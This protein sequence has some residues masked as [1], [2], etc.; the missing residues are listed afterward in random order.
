MMR[1]VIDVLDGVSIGPVIPPPNLV[2]FTIILGQ[3]SVGVPLSRQM[4]SGH[5]HSNGTRH[6]WGQAHG[7]RRPSAGFR[8]LLPILPRF[9]GVGSRQ[10]ASAPVAGG[11]SGQIVECFLERGDCCGSLRNNILLGFLHLGLEPVE[12]PREFDP[13]LQR[14]LSNR[15]P[16]PTQLLAIQ[17][18]G[19][20]AEAEPPVRGSRRK[21]THAFPTQGR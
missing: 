18:S 7:Q 3:R 16:L 19:E 20:N 14:T 11:R 17:V 9:N 1:F 2:A 6:G 12:V 4:R 10:Q 15:L 8:A 5:L 21:A 13:A